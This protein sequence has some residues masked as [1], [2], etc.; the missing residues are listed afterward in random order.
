M[1]T[2]PVN[3]DHGWMLAGLAD[4]PGVLLAAVVDGDG[5]IRAVT[6]NEVSEREKAFLAAIAGTIRLFEEP[7]AWFGSGAEA[8]PAGGSP[9][10][11]VFA[12]ALGA[13]RDARAPACLVVLVTDV[14]DAEHVQRSITDCVA[15]IVA[16]EHSQ[17]RPT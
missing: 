5:S 8:L 12:R 7:P 9:E 2:R 3:G 4:I 16:A 10:T 13:G 15:Q 11:R 14:V 1:T 17:H 6:D